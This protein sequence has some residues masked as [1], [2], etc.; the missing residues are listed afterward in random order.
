MS[1]SSEG[2][3]A[4][5]SDV[6]PPTEH[7]TRPPFVPRPDPLYQ[8]VILTMCSVV[9]VLA[10]VLSVRDRTEVLVPILGVPLPELCMFRRLTGQ[11]CP[12]CGMTRCFISLAHGDVRAAWAYNPAGLFLFALFAFQIPYRAWQLWRIRRGLPEHNFGRVGVAALGIFAAT[13]VGQ[14]AVRQIVGL[15]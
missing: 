9:I 7:P 13:M 6:S 2:P 3:G 10:L 12:G 5:T 14:W 11:G 4:G 8:A 15:F 1:G